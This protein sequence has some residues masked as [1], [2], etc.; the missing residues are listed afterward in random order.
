MKSHTG[1]PAFDLRTLPRA[2]REGR[3]SQKDLGDYLKKLP[4]EAK[5]AE[6]IKFSEAKS[7]PAPKSPGAKPN[8][9]AF[10]AL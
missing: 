6:E 2:L 7:T 4:D 5:Q 8:P 1:D 3:V 10:E 9:P